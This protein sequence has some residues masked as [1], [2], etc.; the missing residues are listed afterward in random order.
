MKMA[1]SFIICRRRVVSRRA[2]QW[3]VG[4]PIEEV[5]KT[6]DD[7]DPSVLRIAA[8][9]ERK[10]KERQRANVSRGR[11]VSEARRVEEI[12]DSDSD[13]DGVSDRED[14]TVEGGETGQ[15]FEWLNFSEAFRGEEEVIRVHNT[16]SVNI[17]DCP[18]SAFRSLWSD[19]VLEHIVLQTNLYAAKLGSTCPQFAQLWYDTNADEILCLF[20]FW[21]M[22]DII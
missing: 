4:D 11:M 6:D 9:D 15:T 14:D 20:A 5:F 13:N 3:Q 22:L 17:H 7:I 21:M 18:Y 12:D 8:E 16:G 10:R 19:E 2:Q 1:V